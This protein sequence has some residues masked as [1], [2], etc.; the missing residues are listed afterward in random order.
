MSELSRYLVT[1]R[2]FDGSRSQ[3]YLVAHDMETAVSETKLS[4]HCKEIISVVKI[5]DSGPKVRK[6]SGFVSNCL[7]DN[8][9]E[10]ITDQ[11]HRLH[12]GN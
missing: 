9:N 3:S 8:L 10:Q 6:R 2:A 5:E 4:P 7:S 1:F 12:K 11:L